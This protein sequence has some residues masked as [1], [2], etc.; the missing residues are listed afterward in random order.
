[1]ISSGLVGELT[2]AQVRRDDGA[3]VDLRDTTAA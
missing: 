2:R 1:M 3:W